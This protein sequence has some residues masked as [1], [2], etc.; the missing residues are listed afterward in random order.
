MKVGNQTRDGVVVTVQKDLHEV[1]KQKGKESYMNM[2]KNNST[3]ES[4]D[5]I[6]RE[7]AMLEKPKIIDAQDRF[8]EFLDAAVANRIHTKI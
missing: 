2:W 3:P 1:K 7:T 8:K 4:Q 5:P 6:T